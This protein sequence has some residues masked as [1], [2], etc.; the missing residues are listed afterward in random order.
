MWLASLKSKNVS[1][2]TADTILL[3][4]GAR[5]IDKFLGYLNYK[6]PDKRFTMEG[7][8]DNTFPFLDILVSQNHNTFES[9]VF[10]DKTFTRLSS[11]FL[12]SEY[13]IY[14]INWIKTFVQ[15]LPYSLDLFKSSQGGDFSK[16]FLYK[17]LS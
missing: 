10:Q 8:Q 1:S 4:K 13:K 5:H 2:I 15:M 6:H 11:H 17:Y 3:F 12:S 7:E 16:F 9:S 14:K